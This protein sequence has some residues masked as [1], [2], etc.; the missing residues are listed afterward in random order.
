MPIWAWILIILLIVIAL[1]GSGTAGTRYTR[2]TPRSALS[3]SVPATTELGA[4]AAGELSRP[5]R[6]WPRRQP[7]R[8]RLDE[9]FPRTRRWSWRIE[10]LR[11]ASPQSSTSKA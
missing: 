7:G 10:P 6:P 3:V 2:R 11:E 5:E 8:F 4:R 1:G 9:E